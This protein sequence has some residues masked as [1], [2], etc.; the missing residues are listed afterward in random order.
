MQRVIATVCN[1]QIEMHGPFA[2][3]DATQVEVTPVEP[4]LLAAPHVVAPMSEWPEGFFERSRTD[5]GNEPFERPPQGEFE[6]R[7]DW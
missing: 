6:Q 7:E 5:W 3:P 4:V 2:W 1:G